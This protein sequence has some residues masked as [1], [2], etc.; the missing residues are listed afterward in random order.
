M[1]KWSK[2][3]VLNNSDNGRPR[4]TTHIINI[5]GMNVAIGRGQ[6]KVQ[7]GIKMSEELEFTTK[8]HQKT[9]GTFAKADFGSFSVGDDGAGKRRVI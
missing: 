4:I 8:K 5:F 9:S 1:I 2:C 7:P 6:R 3:L